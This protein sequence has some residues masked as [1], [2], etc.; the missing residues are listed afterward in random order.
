MTW[1]GRES[2]EWCI[3]SLVLGA[4]SHVCS[5]SENPLICVLMVHALSY[6]ILIKISKIEIIGLPT[7]QY[8]FVV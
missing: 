1:G 3:L 8:Y 2:E 5:V 7:S 6:C 4:G